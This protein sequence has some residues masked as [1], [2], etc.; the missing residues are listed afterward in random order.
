MMRWTLENGSPV[1]A[2][3]SRTARTC[4]RS[5]G[6]LCARTSS[7]VG[8]TSPGSKPWTR[9]VSDDHHQ[10]PVPRSR[11]YWPI[12]CPAP[13]VKEWSMAWSSTDMSVLRLL[14]RMRSQ[15]QTQPFDRTPEPEKATG[16]EH[17][18]TVLRVSLRPRCRRGHRPVKKSAAGAPLARA[19]LGPDRTVARRRTPEHR[20]RTRP[21]PTARPE[22]PCCLR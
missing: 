4:S 22:T 8:T 15:V 12:F 18:E 19:A 17:R 9:Y 21:G 7:V 3:R 2:A 20:D 14:Q 13:R 10:V 16:G 1:A 6:C 5:S 11:R